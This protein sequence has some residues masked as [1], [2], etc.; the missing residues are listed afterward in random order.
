LF[1]KQKSDVER[2]ILRLL[3]EAGS[4]VLEDESLTNSLDESK[5]ITV[6]ITHKL[7]AA[8][9]LSERIEASRKAFRPVAVHGARLFFAVQSLPSLDPMYHFSMSWFRDLFRESLLLG[10]DEPRERDPALRGRELKARFRALLFENASMG[11]FG[12]HQLAFAFLIATKVHEAVGGALAHDTEAAT[13]RERLQALDK[14]AA[15]SK[16][17][18]ASRKTTSKRSETNS[19]KQS[20]HT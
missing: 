11:L 12:H 4:D 9:H 16:F 14:G 18:G 20:D 19:Q 17:P 1:R 2:Q 10:E 15:T 7:A 6:D 13:F 8:G 5:R 3:R